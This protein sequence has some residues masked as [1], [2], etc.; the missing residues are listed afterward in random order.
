MFKSNTT[1]EQESDSS[2]FSYSPDFKNFIDEQEKEKGS[3]L[4]Y[5]RVNPVSEQTI[6]QTNGDKL[7][8]NEYRRMSLRRDKGILSKFTEN[9]KTFYKWKILDKYRYEYADGITKELR[10]GLLS[11]TKKISKKN[12]Q[13]NGLQLF[14]YMF[15]ASLIIGP[16]NRKL[17]LLKINS[18]SI[19]ERE[20]SVGDCIRSIDGEI[21]STGS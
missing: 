11:K 10:I 18:G 2:S 20:L 9:K 3:K 8:R 12:V 6:H 1:L 14:E 21:I 13:K 15:H 17:L 5:L 7:F 19:F 4:F 16:D